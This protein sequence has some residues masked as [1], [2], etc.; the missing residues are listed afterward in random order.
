MSNVP[1]SA[2]EPVDNVK[3]LWNV[4][5]PAAPNVA[6]ML[7]KEPLSAN[8]PAAFQF[9]MRSQLLVRVNRHALWCSGCVRHGGRATTVDM[10]ASAT[11]NPL[12]TATEHRTPLPCGQSGV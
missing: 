9:H 1:S 11:A 5:D 4:G 3:E 6:A 8:A 7:A 2:A 10:M 12:P